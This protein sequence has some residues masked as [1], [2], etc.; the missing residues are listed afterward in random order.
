[1]IL[2]LIG[3]LLFDAWLDGSIND[4]VTDKAVKGS[5]LF[6]LMVLLIFPAVF[7]LTALARRSGITIFKSLAIPACILAGGY[8]YVAQF[9]FIHIEPHIY[10]FAVSA[11]TLAATFI[12]QAK[13]FGNNKVFTNCGGNCFCVLYIGFFSAFFIGIRVDFGLWPLMMFIFTVKSA[14]IGAYFVGSKLGK[15]KFSPIISPN[16]TWEGMAGAVLAS[17]IIA[18]AFAKGFDIMCWP[19]AVLFGVVFAFAGQLGDLAESMLK[20]D[21]QAKDS[22]DVVPGFGG[23]LDIIDSPLATAFLAY[24]FFMMVKT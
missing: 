13:R 4:S 17:T 20:R 15:H 9:K 12:Y 10:V 19:A 24:L 14:D 5:L 11:F 1:M 22:D 21:A 6:M 23:V 16:K 18:M 2:L 7:E 8:W 3:I